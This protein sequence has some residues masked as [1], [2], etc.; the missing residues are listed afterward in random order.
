MN[1]KYWQS[2]QNKIN[3]AKKTMNAK[4][5]HSNGKWTPEA[6]VAWEKWHILERATNDPF[7]YQRNTAGV[8]S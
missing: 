1:K 5:A 6:T 2:I 7:H 3:E 8:K 4:F